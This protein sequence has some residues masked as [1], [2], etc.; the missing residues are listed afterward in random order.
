[1]AARI[2]A[3]FW[4]FTAA[5]TVHSFAPVGKFQRKQPRRLQESLGDSEELQARRQFLTS[6]IGGTTALG[7]PWLLPPQSLAEITDET[8]A[9]ATNWWTDGGNKGKAASPPVAETP[10]AASPQSQRPV[11]DEVEIVLFK[12]DLKEAGGLGLELADIEFRTNLRVYVKSVRPESL[13][14]LLGIQ[15]GWVVV[16][17]CRVPDKNFRCPIDTSLTLKTHPKILFSPQWS[18]N[19]TYEF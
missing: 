7:A 2:L 15:K 11:S 8:D 1:M 4:A 12:A 14:S 3:L 5:C 16:C 17:K 13:A 19:G 9:Y 18:I 10:S 6:I